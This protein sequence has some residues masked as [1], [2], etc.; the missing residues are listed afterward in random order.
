MSSQDGASLSPVVLE[1]LLS[2][3][4]GG[5]F[6]RTN[7][8]LRIAEK[9]CIISARFPELVFVY[10]FSYVFR[11]HLSEVCQGGRV[12]VSIA[13]VVVVEVFRVAYLYSLV[14]Q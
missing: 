9:F 7:Q 1:H 3:H 6:E 12:K 2:P 4:V 14:P 13:V 5:F 11:D 8:E 10:L